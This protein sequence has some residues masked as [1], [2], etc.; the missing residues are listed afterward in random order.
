MSW[1]FRGKRDY[2]LER[3]LFS[4]LE[5]EAAEQQENGLSE[6]EARY[7]ARRAFGNTTVVKEEVHE[8]LGS[9]TLHRLASD[10]GQDLRY[11]FRGMRRDAGFTTFVI[12]IAGAGRKL[13][14]A[15][16]YSVW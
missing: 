5:S 1:W 15:Q 3:E 12:L 14:P 4:H 7:A 2:D 16:R 6:P 8:M 9:G 11:S 10:L 13:E